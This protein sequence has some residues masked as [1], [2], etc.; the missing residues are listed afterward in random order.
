MSKV[1]WPFGA[2]DTKNYAYAAT[3]ALEIDN[4]KTRA[5]IAQMTGAANLTVTAVNGHVPEVGDEI[6]LEV[7][8][9]GT[10]RVLTPSTGAT[11]NAITITANKTFVI[12]LRYN[13]T[14]WHV[15]SSLVTN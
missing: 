9:D 6:M 1:K 7:S 14:T 10:N 5:V 4:S 2:A 8:A 3:V 15:V 13:G 12:T 11:G